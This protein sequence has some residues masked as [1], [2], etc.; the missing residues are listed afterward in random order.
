[1]LKTPPGSSEYTMYKDE[2]SEPA[3]LVC[4]VGSTKL[5][6]DLRRSRICTAGCPSREIGSLLV[7]LTSNSQPSG[8]V[9]AWPI[10]RQSHRRMLWLAQG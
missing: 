3:M 1:M 5:T 8:T 6:Y 4:Q 9:E 10:D 7:R 2:E